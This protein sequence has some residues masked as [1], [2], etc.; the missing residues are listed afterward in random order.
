MCGLG[1]FKR[2]SP[3]HPHAVSY[4]KAAEADYHLGEIDLRAEASSFNFYY[5]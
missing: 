2:I 1:H 5:P 4:G 3:G